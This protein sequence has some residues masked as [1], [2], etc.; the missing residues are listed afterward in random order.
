MLKSINFMKLLIERTLDFFGY[1]SSCL[2]IYCLGEVALAHENT[3][4]RD[5][6]LEAQFK[7]IG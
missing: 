4:E 6:W 3:D 5:L 1:H 7:S 2:M